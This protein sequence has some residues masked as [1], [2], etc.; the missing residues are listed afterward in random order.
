MKE[1]AKQCGGDVA[2]FESVEQLLQSSHIASKINGAIICTPHATHYQIVESLIKE[3][4]KR[5]EENGVDDLLHILLEKPMTTDV[6]EARKLHEMSNAYCHAVTAGKTKPYLQLNH[7]ANFR[8]QTMVASDLIQTQKA[9]GNIRHINASMASPLSWLFGHPK[10]AS[11]NKPTE[12]M[13][14]NGFAWGQSSHL[15]A[16]IYHVCGM[17]LVPLSVYCIMNHSESSGAD[18]SHSATIK[19]QNDITFSLAGTCLLPGNEHGD[20]PIGKEITI[21]IYG[22][23][24][25]L[26]YRGNDHDPTSGKLEIRMGSGNDDVVEGSVRVYCEELGFLFENT[27]QEGLGPESLQTFVAACCGDNE[28]YEGANTL[29]GLKSIQTL[30][31]MYRSHHSGAVENIIN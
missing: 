26:F 23:N 13:L 1:L 16:W 10:N 15:L 6:N 4:K 19:C 21:E 18:M 7:S 5:L 28:Y 24:G 27:A 9:I 17:E 12:G 30:D 14:G 29:V 3:G 25:A 20:P 8:Q 31:A 2:V 22:S 11:W